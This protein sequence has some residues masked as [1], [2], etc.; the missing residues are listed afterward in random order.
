MKPRGKFYR[1]NYFIQARQVRLLD[2]TGKQIGVVTKEEALR[3]GRE[4]SKDVVEIASNAQPPVAKLIDFKKFK[5]LEAKKTREEKKKQKNV[6][7]KEIRLRPFIG[8]H[9][10]DTRLARAKEFLTDGN[11]L[12]ISIPFRGREIT[13]KEFGHDVLNRF[14]SALSDIKVVRPAHFEGKVLIAQVV[15]D[16]KSPKP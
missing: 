8:Q 4:A 5:Y 13:R 11:Q 16:K 12:K 9:D 3:L 7:V 15:G 6:G 1:L 10:L 2:E 14:L